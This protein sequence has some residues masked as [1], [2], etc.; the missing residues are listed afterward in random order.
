MEFKQPPP[1]Q[2]RNKRRSLNLVL[3]ILF[4]VFLFTTLMNHH[5]ERGLLVQSELEERSHEFSRKLYETLRMSVEN[6]QAASTV[7]VSFKKISYTQF[8]AITA[9]YFKTDPGLIIVEWQPVVTKEN[10]QQFVIETQANGLPNFRLWEPDANGEPI[11]ATVRDIHV[12]V[13]FMSSRDQTQNDVNTLGLDLAWSVERM[14]SK[15]EARD[16]GRARSSEL[17]KIVTG[18]STEYK[19]LGFAITLPVYRNGMVPDSQE[20]RRNNVIGYMAGVYHL[21]KLIDQSLKDLKEQGIN[22]DIH[23]QFDNGNRL[24]VESDKAADFQYEV[25]L[26]AFGNSIHIQLTATDRF[27]SKQFKTTWI[28]LPLFIVVS[29]VL[30]VFFVNELGK[31][32]ESLAQARNELERVN[33]QLT[34]LSRHDSLTNLYNR[35]AFLEIVSLELE[36]L[37]RHKQTVALLMLDLDLFKTINDSWGHPVGDDV[38]KAFAQACQ[39]CSR[40]VDVIGRIGGEEFA[41]LLTNTS[42]EEAYTYAERLRETVAEL[43]IPIQNQSDEISITVSIGVAMTNEP[44]SPSLML[45]QADK[46]LYM[47]KHSGRN[48]VHVYE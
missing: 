16:L 28:L 44:M 31:K 21:E 26:D 48:L 11:S 46:A 45:E 18:Q 8:N 25:E 17:F 3:G 13:L 41:I 9:S 36:R 39:T 42:L 38:L 34:E 7:I 15:W 4:S 27:V 14:Q 22:I 20:A 29:G 6:L 37:K 2:L 5:K 24:V 47:A 19:P 23:D 12:P 10:R 32:A 43:R 1:E 30:T 35:R 33:V 40:N